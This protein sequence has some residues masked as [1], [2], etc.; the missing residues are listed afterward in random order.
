MGSA[1]DL[2]PPYRRARAKKLN[3]EDATTGLLE[4]WAA[5]SETAASAVLERLYPDLLSLAGRHQ[6]RAGASS[7]PSSLAQELCIRLLGQ[8]RAGWHCRAH[9]FAVAAKLIRRLAVDRARREQRLKRGSSQRRVDLE[10]I[11]PTYEPGGVDLIA[12]DAGLD[13]LA[14]MSPS[15]ARVVEMRFFAGLSIEETATV[16]EVGRTTVVRRW[17]L[18]KAWLRAVMNGEQPP[19]LALVEGEGGSGSPG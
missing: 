10:E 1:C 15:T 6:W 11:E 16:L 5:G 3:P 19:D 18:A 9:F 17:R 7:T 4:Q 12:L 13:R 2:A 14:R 8:R